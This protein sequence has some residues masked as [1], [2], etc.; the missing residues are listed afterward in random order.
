MFDLLYQVEYPGGFELKFGSE[1]TP[2]QVKD[3]PTVHWT[4]EE[5][6]YYTLVMIDPDAPSKRRPFF[7]PVKHWLVVNI[8]GNDL[9]KGESLASYHGAGAHEGTLKTIYTW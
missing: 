8:P 3:E 6:Q 1:L 2:R 9:K 7:G 4:V 5:G